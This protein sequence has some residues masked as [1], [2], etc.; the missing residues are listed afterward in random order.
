MRKFKDL[1][2]FLLFYIVAFIGAFTATYFMNIESVMLKVFVF[3][4]IAT[5]IVYI[6]SVICKNSSVYDPY[7]SVFP[8]GAVMYLI[9]EFE[10]FTTLHMLVLLAILVWSFRLTIN[11]ITV[12][13]GF[14]YEDWR[15]K[16]YREKA[17]NSKLM[18]FIY[19]FFGIHMVPTLFVFGGMLP[20]FDIFALETLNP[21]TFVGIGIILLGVTFE[22]LAD[23]SMHK[24]LDSKQ[25]GVCKNG[26]WKYSRHP[27]Y[28]GEMTNWVGIFVCMIVNTQTHW[29]YVVGCLMIIFMF[30]VISIPLAENRLLPMIPEYKEYRETVSRFLL[31]P[32]KRHKT[33]EK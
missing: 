26:V 29:Y 19:N 10:N 15:Y 7:W 11:W 9:I 4:V 13:S 18:W 21:W 25:K 23:V 8:G 28:L 2:I 27:N 31:L 17:G 12:T 5:V 30:N 20:M 16:H 6:F 14:S 33:S 24:F 32:N 22:I 1:M 3:D